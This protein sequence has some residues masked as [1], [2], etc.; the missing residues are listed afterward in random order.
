MIDFYNAFISYKHAPLDTKVAEHVQRNLEHFHIPHELRKKTGR[1]KIERIFRDKDELPITS[2]L[3]DTISN[4]LEK[5]E[6]LIVICSPNTKQSIWVEREINFFLKNHTKN[7]ILTVLADGEPTEVIPEILQQDERVV[8]DEDGT[9]RKI[10]VNIE[11]LSCDYRMPFNKAKKLELPRLAAALIGCSYDELVRRQRAYRTRRL[12]LVSALVA[13]AAIAFGTYMYMAKQKVDNALRESLISQSRY[14][15]SESQ[16][17]LDQQRR[18]DGLYLALAAVPTDENDPR[19]VTSEGIAALTRATAAY[20]GMAGNNVDCVW[21]YNVGNSVSDMAVNEDGTRLAAVNSLG[22]VTVWNTENHNELFG[23]INQDINVLSITFADGDKL[24]VLGGNKLSAYDST[25]G[26]LLWELDAGSMASR[27]DEWMLSYNDAGIEV[28]QDGQIMVFV[29]GCPAAWIIDT[30]DGHVI[31]QYDLTYDIGGYN[32]FFSHYQLSPDKS[33]ICFSVF[34]GL[35]ENYV[36]VY[37]IRSGNFEL[38]DL[39]NEY[40]SD[41]IWYDDDRFLVSAFDMEAM[42]SVRVEDSYIIRPNYTDIF[43]YDPDGLDLNWQAEHVCNNINLFR[44]FITLQANDMVAFYS[45]DTCTAYN[46]DSG[47]VV[48]NWNTNDPI[49]DVSDRDNDGWPMMITV[50]GGMAFASPRLGT[51]VVH[52]T[53]E[54]TNE[55]NN[56]IVNHGVY[57]YQE[58]GEEIIYY[59]VGVWDDEWTQIEGVTASDIVAYHLDDEVFTVLYEKDG[60]IRM[61]CVDPDRAQLSWDV[62][63]DF[64]GEYYFSLDILGVYDG[65]ILV[66]NNCN[67]LHLYKVDIED[68]SIEQIDITDNVGVG[69]S[70]FLHGNYVAYLYTDY[71]DYRA[72]IYNLE[73]GERQSFPISVDNI[74]SINVAPRCY[75][76]LGCLYVPAE[77]GDYIIRIED[78]QISRVDLPPDW[79]GTVSLS[80]DVQSE[81]FI[82]SDGKQIIFVNDRGTVEFTISTG[83][84][85]PLGMEIIRHNEDDTGTLVVVYSE[86]QL[87][88]YNPGT[89]EFLGSSDISTYVDHICE[90]HITPDWENGYLY[91][92]MDR[93]ESV[94]NLDNWVQEAY[95]ENCFGHHTDSDRF[96]TMS[97][98]DESERGIGYYRHYSLQDLIDKARE[99]LGDSF[100]I[101]A[102]IRSLYGL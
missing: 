17:L 55:I 41:V 84:R 96:Y 89:G 10:K 2:D 63:A 28:I 20:R 24:L 9:E 99:I 16:T 3:T 69:N 73:T 19:P 93:L 38:S 22:A 72:G 74:Y 48:Y 76:E 95:I 50:N 43:C 7:Q 37:D 15:A 91:I 66:T 30:S 56:A 18:I 101:P 42:E 64:G 12:I 39:I 23:I 58:Y 102:E 86:G 70:C 1:K 46:I 6:Y 8:K 75:E 40:V 78:E 11:P 88:R 52:L 94:V 71:P 97:F 81:V 79:N 5:A 90:A 21:N 68:G 29:D 34:M 100:E 31:E 65:D 82:V 27:D 59:N 62:S 32:A 53:Y 83:G 35:A 45:G 85:R 92:Q 61:A 60:L 14:L 54:F 57:V 44:G 47:E 51:N 25:A 98:A 33:K 4:A 67:G 26:N 13:S 87:A 49:I 36:G 77:G 80:A